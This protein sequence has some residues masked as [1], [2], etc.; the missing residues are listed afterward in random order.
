[1]IPRS[2]LTRNQTT[3]CRSQRPILGQKP[4]HQ[5]RKKTGR[6]FLHI[7]FFEG[8]R[9]AGMGEDSWKKSMIPLKRPW[10]WGEGGKTSPTLLTGRVGG[11]RSDG[12]SW[13]SL[14]RLMGRGP[15]VKKRGTVFST[16]LLTRDAKGCPSS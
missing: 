12:C 7:S 11:E 15:I 6:I 13:G 8:S 2:F 5:K 10:G 4:D 9:P 1:M 16:L 3:V 14:R